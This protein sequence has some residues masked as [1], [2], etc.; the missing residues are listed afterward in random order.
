LRLLR[1]KKHIVLLLLF[2]FGIFHT[3][4]QN[5]LDL[6][7]PTIIDGSDL[8]YCFSSREASFDSVYSLQDQFQVGRKGVSNFGMTEKAVWIKIVLP[9]ISIDDPYLIINNPLLDKV[10]L[11]QQLPDG[12]FDSSI[13]T[14]ETPLDFRRFNSSKYIFKLNNKIGEKATLVIRISGLE[15]L[16]LPI[17]IKSGDQA[18]RTENHGS[19]FLGIYSGIILIMFVY[20]LFVYFSVRDKSYLFYVIYVFFVGLTQLGIKG[21]N[22]LSF[23]F[24][25]VETQNGSLIVYSSIAAL[26][27]IVFTRDFLHLSLWLPRYDK[28]FKFLA[29]LFILPIILVI[30]NQFAVGFIIMQIAT[31]ISA[32]LI[33]ITSIRSVAAGIKSAR[34]FLIAWSV[35]VVGALIFTLKDLGVLPFNTFT[36]YTLIIASS[37]EMALLS[38]AL[39]DKINVLTAEKEESRLRELDALKENEQLTREQNVILESKVRERTKELL[40]ANL[41]LESVLYNL[42]NAQTQLVS[43]EKMASLGQLTAGIAHEINNPINF[44]SSNV[45]PLKRD[46]KDLVEVIERYRSI[47][48]VDEFEAKRKEV[49]AFLD[50][51]D[52]GYVIKEIDQLVN[53]IQEGADRTAEIVKGLKNFSRLDEVESKSANLHEGI[54]STLLIILSGSKVKVEIVKDYDENITEIECFPGKLNQVFSNILSN[55]FQAM[56]NNPPENRPSM[57]ITTKQMTEHVSVSFKDNGPGIPVKTIEKIYEPFFTTKEVGEGTGLGLSIVFSIIEAHKGKIEVNSEPPNGTEFLITLPKSMN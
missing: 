54:D 12:A 31:I 42:K 29:S 3:M 14:Q 11:Y 57:K 21:I 26:F 44:V 13:A 17:S 20:N 2:W 32:I 34:Y 39:A 16:I 18:Q 27:G 49:E 19:V 37:I 46:I 36:S 10:I 6:L 38:F 33:F 48:S 22:L 43:Q 15:Q 53:G 30:M 41:E 9:K 1:V 51:I 24:D 40:E 35:L 8:V 52:F 25:T 28:L 23:V 5:N 55:G 45:N 4:A 47:V 50:E 7:K 56:E